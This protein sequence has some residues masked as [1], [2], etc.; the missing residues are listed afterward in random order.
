VVNIEELDLQILEEMNK[1][2]RVS[3]TNI[4]K[5]INSSRPT[6]TSRLK[7]MRKEGVLNIAAGLDL[8]SLGYKMALV[9]LEVSGDQNRKKFLEV[10]GKCPR[11]Q[12]IFRSSDIAN[13]K[14]GVWGEDESSINSCIESFRDLANV[15]IVETEYLGTPIRGN[16]TLPVNLG[17][18]EVAP[19]G[20]TCTMCSQY[21]NEWCHGCPVTIYYKN[22]LL[23]ST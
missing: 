14:V 3:I 8:Q 1:E 18:N 16:V 15:R 17:D 12:T 22:P 6:V 7:E 21:E 4:A 10:M 13:I 20:K 9:S 2:G 23:K 11:V 5:R 19:C